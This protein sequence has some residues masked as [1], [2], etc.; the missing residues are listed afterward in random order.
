[1]TRELPGRALVIAAGMAALAGSAERAEASFAPM[2]TAGFGFSFNFCLGDGPRRPPPYAQPWR[3]YGPPPYPAPWYP[4]VPA[5]PPPPGYVYPPYSP[6][7]MPR[8]GNGG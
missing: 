6:Q 8:T 4:G 3:F 7:P 5:Y 2:A 1:M